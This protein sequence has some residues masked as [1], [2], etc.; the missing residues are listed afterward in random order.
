M[1]FH[2]SLVCAGAAMLL[3]ACSTTG[4]IPASNAQAP[5]FSG[6][7][8]VAISQ[9]PLSF[10]EGAA[11]SDRMGAQHSGFDPATVERIAQ[12]SLQQCR[13][14]LAGSRDGFERIASR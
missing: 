12:Q 8:P 3:S 1:K 13:T 9:T 2:S 14:L 10:C 4:A 6:F 11:A 7:T 5:Q